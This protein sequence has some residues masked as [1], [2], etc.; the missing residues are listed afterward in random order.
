MS[1]DIC[2]VVHNDVL[3]DSRI[4]REARTLNARGWKIVVVCIALGNTKLPTVQEVE[5]F[6]IW[7]VTPS[8]FREKTD[9]KTTHK[10]VQLLIALP[11]VL[12]R[13]RLSKA[14][15][16][17]GHDFIG[18]LIIALAGVRRRPVIYRFS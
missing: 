17:H 6:T 16:Y 11:V 12:W 7:R 3:N 13:I 15:V 5:G 9:I 1:F 10:L 14:K 8:I 18:L 4:W 2:M